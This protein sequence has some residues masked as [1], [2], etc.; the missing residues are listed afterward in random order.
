MQGKGKEWERLAARISE[1]LYGP[2]KSEQPLRGGKRADIVVW[3]S[4]I[5]QDSRGN[6]EFANKIIECKEGISSWEDY[7]IEK[8]LKYCRVLEIWCLVPRHRYL[9]DPMPKTPQGVVFKGPYE[10]RANLLARGMAAKNLKAD[11]DSRAVLAKEMWD[12]MWKVAGLDKELII[13]P[14]RLLVC[15]SQ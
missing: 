2:V 15:D 6:V 1:A 13:C 12:L 14:R 3:D 4:S 10:L 5:R 9:N 11:W 7:E 8:Y